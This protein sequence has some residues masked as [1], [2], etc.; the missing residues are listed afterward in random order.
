VKQIKNVRTKHASKGQK[1]LMVP[2]VLIVYKNASMQ[3]LQCHKWTKA[4]R[5]SLVLRKPDSMQHNMNYDERCNKEFYVWGIPS[6]STVKVNRRFGG[7]CLLLFAGLRSKPRIKQTASR[8]SMI[9]LLFNPE[10]WSGVFLRNIS[11]LSP[12]LLALYSGRSLRNHC[13]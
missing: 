10:D 13:C 7:T 9:G 11:W 2:D 5:K 3:P 12:D 8:A 6:C 1:F 4:E